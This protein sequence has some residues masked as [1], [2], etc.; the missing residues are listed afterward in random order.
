MSF[1]LKNKI[2]ELDDKVNDA[3]FDNQLKLLEDKNKE[4]I[5]KLANKENE[6]EQIDIEFNSYRKKF[7]D[8]NERIIA[9]DK[10]IEDLEFKICFL[11]VQI[12]KLYE[13]LPEDNKIPEIKMLL[14]YLNSS[15]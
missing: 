14:N 7:K 4:L 11:L 5:N 13:V 1:R 6:L 10:K 15:N 8:V 2:R 3:E 9:K 12:N